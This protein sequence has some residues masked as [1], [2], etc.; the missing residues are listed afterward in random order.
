MI[1]VKVELWS[2]ITGQHTELA[3][4]TIANEGTG[5]LVR[6]NY[7]AKT[8]IGRNEATLQKAMVKGTI[9]RSTRITGWPR[10]QWHVW[11]LVERALG[12]MG[13]GNG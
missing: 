6:G 10:Q 11:N 13:Y 8:Y 3:R 5:S 12:N 2:A 1:V 9:S 4:M 7:E